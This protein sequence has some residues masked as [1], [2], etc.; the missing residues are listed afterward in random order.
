MFISCNQI[1]KKTNITECTIIL[2]Q[3]NDI[4]HS[5]LLFDGGTSTCSEWHSMWNVCALLFV[6]HQTGNIDE[7]YCNETKLIFINIHYTCFA[8][9]LSINY[10]HTHKI[11]TRKFF[12]KNDWE[13]TKYLWWMFA[14][15]TLLINFSIL[16]FL[17]FKLYQQ[18]LQIYSWMKPFWMLRTTRF[19][20]S[21]LNNDKL[22]IIIQTCGL[23][24]WMKT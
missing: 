21:W 1:I 18:G 4:S 3:H 7:N 9:G 14:Q 6:C 22:K 13:F 24:H 11:F 19:T 20:Q 8:F 5:I 16:S 17:L 12:D 10:T 2:F 15:L 23:R